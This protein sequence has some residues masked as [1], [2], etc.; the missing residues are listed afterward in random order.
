[1]LNHDSGDNLN[2]VPLVNETTYRYPSGPN[3]KSVMQPNFWPITSSSLLSQGLY[4]KSCKLG[5]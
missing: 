2:M 5:F 3:C 1:M 4:T